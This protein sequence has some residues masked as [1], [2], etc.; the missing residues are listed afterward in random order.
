MFIHLAVPCAQS[1]SLEDQ[2]D[3]WMSPKWNNKR[4]KWQKKQKLM[5]YDDCHTYY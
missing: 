5:S 1:P 4:H 2:R 3:A